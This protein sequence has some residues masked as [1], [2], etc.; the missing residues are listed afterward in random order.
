M[1]QS[2]QVMADVLGVI[3]LLYGVSFVNM[4]QTEGI[5]SGM[6]KSMLA[7]IIAM[8]LIAFFAWFAFSL[9]H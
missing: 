4:L 9:G 1:Y 6:L 2:V 7:Y 5:S 3:G 8:V